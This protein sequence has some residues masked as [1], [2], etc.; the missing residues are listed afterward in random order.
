MKG[1]GFQHQFACHSE[2]AYGAAA[3]E[4]ITSFSIKWSDLTIGVKITNIL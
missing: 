2:H 4:L 1:A 3:M